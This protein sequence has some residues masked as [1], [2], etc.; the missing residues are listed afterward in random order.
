MAEYTRAE[1]DRMQQDAMR[2]VRDMQRR[3]R[4]YV[5]NSPPPRNNP[6]PAPPP[7]P[8]EPIH[9]P[10]EE[11]ECPPPKKNLLEGI[12]PDIDIDEEK[13]LIILLLILLARNGAEMKLLL[14]L[15]YLLM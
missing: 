6:P 11:R 9:I 14:A 1:I 10:D 5:Q 2:R 13:A 4:S 15:G 7:P 3:S 8:E 12:L